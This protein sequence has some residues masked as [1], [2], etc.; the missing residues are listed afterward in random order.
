MTRGRG[1]TVHSTEC[2]RLLDTEAERRV[3][4]TWERGARANRTIRLEIT[5]RDQR[6][7]LARMSQAITSAGVDISRA[8]VRTT[9]EGRAINTFEMVL[10]SDDELARVRRNLL[11]VPGVKDVK[12][13]RT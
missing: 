12:R 6:G 9:G 5:A 11:R 13:L 7:L 8:F 4:V 10:S 1:V 3:E 2:E